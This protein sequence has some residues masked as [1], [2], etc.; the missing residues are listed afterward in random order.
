MPGPPGLIGPTGLPGFTV[1]TPNDFSNKKN[2]P[3]PSRKSTSINHLRDKSNIPQ[4]K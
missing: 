2:L 3:L 4:P 1:S